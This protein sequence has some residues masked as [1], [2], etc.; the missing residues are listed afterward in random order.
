MDLKEVITHSWESLQRNRLRSI[1][2]MLGIVWGLTTVVLLLGYGQSVGD[3]VLGAFMGIGN[4]VI[5]I[6]QGQTSM[7]AGGQRSGRRIHFKY[8]DIQAIRDDVPLVKNVSAEDDDNFAYK[9]GNRVIT[10]STKCVQ[11]PYGEMRKLNMAEGR[12][13]EPADFTEHRRVLIMGPHAAKKIFGGHP[14]LGEY[15]SVWGTQFQVIGILALKIQDS[16]NNGPDNENVFMPFETAGDFISLRDPGMIVFQPINPAMHKEALLGVRTVLG[17]RHNFEPKDD[18]ATP[19]W[20]TIEDSEEL[21]QFSLALQ[22]LL[23]FIG[24][25]T[26]GVGG[27]GVMNIM[28][29]SVTERTREVGLRKAIGARPRDIAM[30]F[31]AEALLLTFVAGAVGMLVAVIL[32][33]SIP[34]MPLY[35]E[36]FK[37]VN[38][39]GDIFLRTSLPVMFSSFLILAGVGI[40][41]GL[42]PAMKAASMDPVEALRY[43]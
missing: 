40:F 17:Q 8:E 23:G 28:L 22:V 21:K 36:S 2:T 30:Q 1:L 11:Y 5:M 14:P 19:E 35:S 6:W 16:S 4:N 24:A 42:W 29:V 3:S 33:H 27:V 26:L 10:V 20:D 12:Y 41:A 39:E 13:F 43:E 18:K 32:A 31:F 9:Y 34:P 7:Q 25:L 38:H 15:V 37:T